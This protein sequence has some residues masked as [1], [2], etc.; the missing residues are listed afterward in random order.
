MTLAASSQWAI[1]DDATDGLHGVMVYFRPGG[2]PVFDATDPNQ[3]SAQG[4]FTVTDRTLTLVPNN[5]PFGTTVTMSGGDFG[6]DAANKVPQLL[7][8]YQ[9]KA[10]DF[11][12]L[13]SSGDI[14]PVTF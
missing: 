11:Q 13:S 5:I 12:P 8:N 1:P 10:M 9:L 14:V 3:V 2:N 6:S 7:V 4:T